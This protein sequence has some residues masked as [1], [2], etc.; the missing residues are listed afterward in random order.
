MLSLLFFL[1]VLMRTT[2]TKPSINPI[3]MNHFNF[4]LLKFE[5][6]LSSAS[7]PRTSFVRSGNLLVELSIAG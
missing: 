6:S 4:E 7:F 2:P 1:V 3:V 5:L